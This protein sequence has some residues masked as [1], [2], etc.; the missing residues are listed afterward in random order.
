MNN[1]NDISN[2]NDSNNINRSYKIV[3]TE[4][5]KCLGYGLLGLTWL[6]GI[7]MCIIKKNILQVWFI[8]VCIITS[9]FCIKLCISLKKKCI[10]HNI[11]DIEIKDKNPLSNTISIIKSDLPENYN[12]IC[13]IC[14]DE[15]SKDNKVCLIS[16]CKYHYYHIECIHKYIEQGFTNC[17]MCNV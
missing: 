5:E 9:V 3:I 10:I 11:P 6:V 13:P 15:I 2:N 17:P 8:L 4:F 7:C 14:L 12:D 16:D 1:S